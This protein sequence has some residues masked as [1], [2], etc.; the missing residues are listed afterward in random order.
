MTPVAPSNEVVERSPAEAQEIPPVPPLEGSPAAR[1]E[2]GI[3]LPA[4]PAATAPTATPPAPPSYPAAAQRRP[5]GGRWALGIGLVIF[6]GLS[7]FI[8]GWGLVFAGSNVV[9]AIAVGTIPALTCLAAAW[10][11]RSWTGAV[12]VEVV[13]LAISALMWMWAIVGVG[14]IQAWAVAF[15]LYAALPAVVLGAIGTA[16]GMAVAGRRS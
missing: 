3:S 15:P 12:A 5:S 13:Y 8:V 9:M 4:G 16:I 1:S 14:D 7:W 2:A 10:L 11:L 6:G